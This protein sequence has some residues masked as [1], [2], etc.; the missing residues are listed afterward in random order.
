MTRT[1]WTKLAIVSLAV[2]G[3]AIPSAMALGPVDVEAG[4]Y[5][6]VHDLDVDVD[7][8]GESFSESFDADAPGLFARVWISKVGI[9]GEY[10]SSD[11]DESGVDVQLD[12]MSIDARFKLIELTNSNYL[13][14][15]G[16]LQQIDVDADGGSDDSLGGRAVIE[17]NVG[18]GRLLYA[19]GE[20]VYYVGL[21]DLDFGEGD[22]IEDLEGWELEVGVSI[23]PAPFFNIKVGYRQTQL[24]GDFPGGSASWDGDGFIAGLSFN[25]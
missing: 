2:F 5:Y 19:Y 7:E 25:F 11:V 22:K 17:G 8:D 21:D 16:G 13:A 24:D 1:L 14:I 23:K 15:G 12:R 10:Y 20:G 4:A 9:Y 18:I 6:W 3:L